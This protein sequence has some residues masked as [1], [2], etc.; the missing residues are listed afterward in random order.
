MTKKEFARVL[1]EKGIFPSKAEAERKLD[2]ILGPG[3]AV[4]ERRGRVDWSA[5]SRCKVSG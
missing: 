1:F 5:R 2:S 3:P 4:S